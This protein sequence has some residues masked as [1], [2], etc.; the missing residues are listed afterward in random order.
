M[1]NQ[2]HGSRAARRRPGSL[3]TNEIPL[4]RPGV[5]KQARWIVPQSEGKSPKMKTRDTLM[6]RRSPAP[7]ISSRWERSRTPGKEKIGGES[8]SG[9]FWSGE[10]ERDS[11]GT[12]DSNWCHHC[13]S[14]EVRQRVCLSGT[15]D[16]MRSDKDRRHEE[17]QRPTTKCEPGGYPTSR[18]KESGC[19]ISS[20]EFDGAYQTQHDV[21]DA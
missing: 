7:D 10:I 11:A 16:D 9:G 18:N 14:T 6:P 12:W 3:C 5:S 15:Q 8:V 13:R 19:Q 21:V 1:A 2:F 20:F 4:I 17:R